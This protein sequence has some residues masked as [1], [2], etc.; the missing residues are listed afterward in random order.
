M[1]HTRI[2]RLLDS[3]SEH[4]FSTPDRNA[5][6]SGYDTLTA[7]RSA[8]TYRDPRFD[9]LATMRAAG[10]TC[11]PV[12]HITDTCPQITHAVTA[13]ATVTS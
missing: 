7:T 8:R 5:A 2:G 1:T 10:C 13:A 12:C 9:H 3:L 11:V 6:A 4:L